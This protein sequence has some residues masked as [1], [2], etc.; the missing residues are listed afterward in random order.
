MKFKSEAEEA[1]WLYQHRDEID[2][3]W[4]P[5]RDEHGK[6]LTPAEIRQREIRRRESVNRWKAF[7]DDELIVLEA[8]VKACIKEQVED[9]PTATAL[10]SEIFYELEDRSGEDYRPN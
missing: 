8:G 9:C 10:H 1:D 5:V 2:A 6:P 7:T 4:K 3:T